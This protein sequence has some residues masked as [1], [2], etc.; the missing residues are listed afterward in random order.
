MTT[1]V[2]SCQWLQGASDVLVD[3]GVWTQD[4]STKSSNFRELYNLVLRMEVL[5]KENKFAKRTEVFIFTDNATAKAAFYKGTSKSK[6]LFQLVL[7]LCKLEMEGQ[8]FI[9]IVWVAGTCMIAQGTDGLLQGD[10]TNGV[11]ARQS[12]LN[13]VPLNKTVE[14]R[15]PGFD[16]FLLESMELFSPKALAPNGWFDEAFKPGHFVWTPPPAAALEALE[17]L[18][19]SKQI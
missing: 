13:F 4:Y 2:E 7:R 1:L 12:M 18:C 19:D 8:L 6:L 16:Q 15:Q 5:M 9:H 17:Q 3:H 10:L 11:L 14:E